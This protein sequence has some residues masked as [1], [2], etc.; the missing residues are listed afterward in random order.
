MTSP[1]VVVT[2]SIQLVGAA[3]SLMGRPAP[4]GA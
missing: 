3:R 2:G 4:D 1:A